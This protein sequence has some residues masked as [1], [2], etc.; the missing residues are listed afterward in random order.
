MKIN[1]IKCREERDDVVPEEQWLIG[2]KKDNLFACQECENVLVTFTDYTELKRVQ[3]KL[4]RHVEVL[5]RTNVNLEEFAYAALHD[6]KGPVRKIQVFTDRLKSI[7]D[8]LL[9]MSRGVFQ[10]HRFCC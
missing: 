5:K 3:L 4:E 9:A 1:P 2:S 10:T 6:L 7:L 8:A